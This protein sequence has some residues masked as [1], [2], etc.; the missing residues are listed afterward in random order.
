[1]CGVFGLG[2]IM[3]VN[4]VGIITR[5]VTNLLWCVSGGLV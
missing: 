3:N 4:Y 2:V 1:M 5:R